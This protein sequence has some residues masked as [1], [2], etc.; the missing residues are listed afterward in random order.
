[1]AARNTIDKGVVAL[2]GGSFVEVKPPEITAPEVLYLA[3]RG[4]VSSEFRKSVETRPVNLVAYWPMD[5]GDGTVAQD[6]LGRFT[7]SLVGG[8]TWTTGR[9]GSG[10]SFNGTDGHVITQATGELLGIDGKKPRTIS[11]WA[12]ASN[13]NPMSQPGFYG[14]GDTNC[15]NG[16]NKYWG[17]RNIKDGG[18]TQL[19]S[20]HWCWD[21]RSNHGTD[22][23]V[24]WVHFA[25]I[26]NGSDVSV[27]INGDLISN[28]TRSQISTGNGQ[29]FQ[30][31]RWRNDTNAYYG[32]EMDDMRVYNDALSENEVQKIFQGEDLKEELVHLQFS[33][34][35]TQSPTSYGVSF[36]PNGLT[37]D[38]LTGEVTG[39]PLQI[40][41]FDVNLTATN[42]AGTGIKQIKLIIDPTAPTLTT[43]SPKDVSSSS[44]RLS[45]RVENDGGAPPALSFFWGD[46]DGGENQSVDLN[47]SGLWDYRIDLNGTYANG[48]VS[49]TINGLQKNGTYYYRLFGGNSVNSAVWSLPS[50]EGL[51]SWWSFDET[52]GSQALDSV[53]SRNA[54]LVGVSESDRI[55]GKVGR[56]LRLN[57][58]GEHVSVKG[59]KGIGAGKQRS[60]ALWLKVPP[61]TTGGSL[62]SWGGSG[63]GANWDFMIENG[64]LKLAVSGGQLTGA[65]I[66]NDD[67]W[68]HVGLVFPAIGTGVEDVVLYVDGSVESNPIK[69]P[70]MINTGDQWDFRVGTNEN[71]N[72]FMGLI[73]EVRLYEKDISSNEMASIF[74]NGTMRFQTSA[75]SLPPVV[76]VSSITPTGGGTATVSGV[77][78]AFDSTQP[79]LKIYW[80][81][82]DGGYD[83]ANWDNS[84]DVAGGVTQGLGEFNA[85][86]SGLLPG[87]T[88]YFRAF[89]SSADGLDWSNGDPEV[90]KSLVSHL[91][92]DESNGTLVYDSSPMTHTAFFQSSDPNASR[93]DG[94]SG[95]ALS[96]NGKDDWLNL[97]ANSSGFLSQSFDG[98]SVSF[99][100]RPTSKV[101]AGPAMTKYEDLVA[102]YP[103]DEGTGSVFGDL[104]VEN[105]DGDLFGAPAWTSAQFGQGLDLDGSNDIGELSAQG[106][107]RDLH[108]NS[109]TISLWVNAD[110]ENL[111]D[112]TQGQLYSHGFLEAI[113]D[114]YYTNIENMFKL[115][116][117]GSS[118]L[119]NGPG[120][121]GLDFNND[122][123][124]RNA[125]IGINRNNNYLSLFNGIF[126]AQVSGPYGWEIRGND[127]RGTIWIDLDQ[128]GV[129]EVAGNKGNEQLVYQPQCCGT[130]STIVMLEAGY[131]AIAIAHGEGGGGSN[132]EA[133]FYTPAGGGATTLTKIKPSD[134]PSLFM[135]SNERTLLKRGPMKLALDGNN[136][137]SYTHG[138]LTGQVTVDS[139]QSLGQ[140]NW[141][142]LALVA[143]YNSST[144]RFYFNGIKTDE[145]LLP[146]GDPV[147][148][149]ATEKWKLGGTNQVFSD[150]FDGK[151]DDMRFY[152]S[153]LN[154]S[155]ILAIF[156]DDLSGAAQAGYQQQ[157]LYDEGTSTSGL[158]ISLDSGVL[159]TKISE[160]SGT[161]ELVDVG[162]INDDKWHHVIVTFGDSPKTFKLYVDGLLKAG[163]SLLTE[164]TVSLHQ[165]V[166]SFGV[167]QGSSQYP[168]YGYFKGELDDFRIYDRG[169]ANSEV[170][171]IFSGDVPNDGFL[172]FLGIEKPDVE[173]KSAIEV[174]PSQAIMRAEIN[175]IG[176]TV[177]ITETTTDRSFK[178]DTIEG[179]AAWFSA[180][181]MNGDL[182]EDI[183]S[184]LG[185]GELV[186]TWNDA[187]GNGRHMSNTLGDPT[188]YLSSFEGKPVVNFDGG[189]LLSSTSSFDF[190]TNDGY[191][192]ISIARYTGGS[193]FRVI[194]SRTRNFLFGYHGGLTGRWYAEGWIST[195]GPFDTDWHLHVG[196]I[197]AKGGNPRAS[198]WRDGTSLTVGS[199]GSNNTNFAPGLLQFG[200]AGRGNGWDKS[201]CEIAEVM[202][203]DRELN[204]SERANIEGYLAHKWRSAEQLLASGHPHL[205]T[206]P[207][208]GVTKVT[209]VVTQGGDP[210]ILKIFW[211]DDWVE[212]NSTAVDENNASK[213]DHVIVLNQGN[214]V[215]LGTYETV[216]GNL[217]QNT[218]YYYRAYAEN[219][220][221]GSWAPSVKAFTA[222]DTR[223]TKHTM[224][225][226]LLWLDA[227]DPDGDGVRN[228]WLNEQ[229]VSLWVD[230]SKNEKNAVQSVPLA[231]PIYAPSVFDDM[232]AMRFAS[233]ESLNIGTLTL[234]STP[235]S[236]FVVAQGS[237]VVIGSNDGSIGWS[238]DAK[239]GIRLGSYRHE[240]NVLQQITLGYDPRTGYGQLIGE[241]GEVMVFDRYLEAD[242]RERI[243]GYLAHKW[244]ITEDLAG[245]TFKVK[246]GLSLYFPFEETD[247]GTVYDSSKAKR[248][249]TLNEIAGTDLSVA[250]KFGSGIKLGDHP[251]SRI[252]MGLNSVD[253]P[254]N[255]TISVWLETPL[256][257]RDSMG[258][259]LIDYWHTLASGAGGDVRHVLFDKEGN[260]E[261]G[262]YDPATVDW[263]TSGY[264]GNSMPAGWH[265]LGAVGLG[266]KTV[267]YVDGVEVGTSNFKINAAIDTIGNIPAGFER[268]TDKIDEFRVYGRPLSSPEI[269]T[270]YGNGLGDFGGHPYDTEAPTFDNV[271]VIKLP[272]NPIVHWSFDEL[273]GTSISD[274]SGLDHNGSVVGNSITNLYDH[275][276]QGRS[277]TALRFDEN[278]SV[279]LPKTSS[280][281]LDNTF[282]L[283]FW[284]NTNDVDAVILKSDQMKVEVSNGFISA[285]VYLGSWINTAEI[286]LT[287]GEWVHYT[288]MWDGS[289]VRFFVNASEVGIPISVS[290]ATLQGTGGDTNTYLG[291]HSSGGETLGGLFDDLRIFNQA[292]TMKELQGVFEFADSQLIARFGEEYE[293]QIESIKGP[294]EYNATGLPQGLEV[295]SATGLIYGEAN[296]TGI[297]SV[298]LRAANPS[299]EDYALVDLVVLKGRQS[300]IFEED[301]GIIVYGDSPIDLNVSSTS[302]L[303]ITFDILEGNESVDLNGSIMTI[304]KPGSV[305]VL[306]RQNGDSHWFAA[307]P[308]PLE[309]QIMKS[310]LVVTAIDQFRSTTESNPTLTYTVQGLVNGDSVNDFNQSIFISTVIGDGNFS[311]PT[312]AGV[313]PITVSNALSELYYFVF[314]NGSLT[315][316]D[317]SLQTLV[318][319]QNLTSV[320]ANLQSVDLQGY[321][322]DGNGTATG[323]PLLYTVEDESVAR[324]KVTRNEDLLAHWKLDEELYSSARDSEGGYHGTLV[325]LVNLGPS[326]SWT[327]GIFSNGL[328]LGSPSGR[329]ELGSVPFDGAFSLSFWLKAQ[330]VN[331]SASTILSK[332]GLLGMNLFKLQKDAGS[333]GVVFSFFGDGNSTAFDLNSSTPVLKQDEWVHLALT[334]DG[335][336][337]LSMYVDALQ[338][339]QTTGISISGMPLDQRYSNLKLGSSVNPFDGL[340]DDLRV[341]KSSLSLADLSQIFG[342]GGG[343]FNQLELVG[344][345]TTKIVASQ[346]GTDVYAQAVPV[347]NYLTVIKVPQS[348][349]FASI[350][351]HSVGDFPFLLEANATSGLS[352]SFSTSDPTRA[353]IN[354]NQV[355]IFGPGEV[356]ITAIQAGDSRFEPAQPVSRSFTIGFGNLFSDSAPGLKLWLDANDVNGDYNRDDQ[357][358]F[359]FGYKVSMWADKSGN[360]NN[361]IQAV[362]GNMTRWLPNTLNEKPVVSFDAGQSF[363]IQN[364]VPSPQFVF[365]VH[366]QSST[367]ASYVLGGDL[368]TTG[369]DGFFE[370]SH[371]SENVRIVSE[372]PSNYW[373]VNSLRVVP[374]GQSLWINGEIVGADSYS[375][376]AIAF[377]QL[378]Q[379][380]MGEIA[381]VL[382]FD[383]AVNSVNRK[384]IEGYLAHKWGLKDQLG[385]LHPYHTDPPAFGG[386]Q[387]ISFPV[388]V[389]KAVGDATFP[390]LA[391]SSS[392]LPVSYVSSNPSVAVVVGN[393]VTVLGA[394]STTITAMQMGDD[395]YH[396]A[397]PVS[398]VLHVVPP[399][400][401]DDQY[402]TFQPIPEKVRDDPAFELNA[403]A[404]SSGVNHPVYSLPVTFTVVSGPASVNAAGVLVLD[405]MEGNVS[406]TATQ[407]GSAYVKAAAP[408]TQIFEVSSRQRQEIRFPAPGTGGL[409]LTPRGHRPL[410]LQGVS[411]TSGLPVQ[412]T[413]SDPS[414]AQVFRG[415]RVIPRKS[416]TVTLTFNSPGN[417]F[418]VPAEPQTKSF[419]V[420]EPS[421]SV[422][423]AF[424]RGDVRY[425]N[426]TSRFS[427]RLLSRNPGL[428]QVEALKIFDEDYTDSDGDGY[429]NLFERALGTDSLGP[430][431]RHDLPMQPLHGDNRQ[432]ISFIRWKADP[433][434][435]ST[436]SN[437]GEVF[438]YHVEQSDDLE[439]WETAGVVLEQVVDLG[440]GM[441]RATYVTS[442]PLPS[443]QRK[444]VR[445]RIT[446]P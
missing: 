151:V 62:V 22:I 153:D 388:L 69:N 5:E 85:T 420:V 187:S 277:G 28:W 87:E 91:R 30:F 167:T 312:P 351:D 116:P 443:G 315:V 257:E 268:F 11:F 88:Y 111:G 322:L 250:G 365:I 415:S 31:G 98:R 311:S 49:T 371:A 56:A 177:T 264:G 421:R 328:D 395:R 318:F 57:G 403:T 301:L 23:R 113:Q 359:I 81:N 77:L 127:D 387:T 92:F 145:E 338:I 341:Y 64:R 140:G 73:D 202:I 254:N 296:Q 434:T 353:V 392:G 408:V 19:I 279:Y 120:G 109:Y 283:C 212:N 247:G 39:K 307:E 419:T 89:A 316:S 327:R 7:G 122:G 210:P 305:R 346:S 14:Y 38:P 386:P 262:V 68:H 372:T 4:S 435:N 440:G 222:S 439:T 203:F 261:L 255:W 52:T 297:F 154:D 168:G 159:R 93:P 97:D 313:Y 103:M 55:F 95:R 321:S 410:V 323:L 413:S 217:V 186:N 58:S 302:G 105:L 29:T 8:A 18:Y 3:Y 209:D 135:T 176:G 158:S 182:T 13:N 150:Y 221:G 228:D 248:N 345:G 230:K 72:H 163:P 337:T 245:T 343:D 191:T 260:K 310:E 329:V 282:T 340:V 299:G 130:Q 21:P 252:T 418:F 441:E 35:A 171:S 339:A 107:L 384:K 407:S 173:T 190:L 411:V 366:R 240:S 112:Y 382:V 205:S 304:K 398:R 426:I 423:K 96:F 170:N 61:S 66:L 193:S 183:G 162:S 132:Q 442:D 444:F 161:V 114:D 179:M 239:S 235:M 136:T 99:R 169:L 269:L 332:D 175:S 317:K 236:V 204:P 78:V 306:A 406:I 342:Q 314:L 381:E 195:A 128:D 42:L 20:Q 94:F 104:G 143:D 402:I 27:S 146:A 409:R 34:D 185:N 393:Y 380:F 231:Q 331:G 272:N 197:E 367:G 397:S 358:D 207:Y 115:T 368:A 46:N 396:P 246:E 178:P 274:S 166:P 156:Q 142:H 405:G 266:S 292:L 249:A 225:G 286:P 391:L 394:G 298:N 237:G 234:G 216:V 361:P 308:L 121:R 360:T 363:D 75:V 196:T 336:A 432:R 349:S 259:L 427:S 344:S 425:Q 106:K 241:I 181:D 309:F 101:Y 117:S 32:G 12:K 50:Q 192:M 251:R 200:G 319:D 389:D 416:G 348:M 129:F 275:S 79:A 238:L 180:Q 67:A 265:H 82:E 48:L 324:L 226:L 376:G 369:P 74:L 51:S 110:S 86:V 417:A 201:S 100:L 37:I 10:L 137:I 400:V 253:L 218:R 33:I 300:I 356:T 373:A 334:F 16:L 370:L 325:N 271:P 220:G 375:Q 141:A 401:K 445:L 24:D 215:T 133:Y 430:D 288:L 124:Y 276:E 147:D 80:G 385:L 280:S 198:F 446:I 160:G 437:V 267:F 118:T 219:L 213:W 43:D 172:E 139:N 126:H 152:A 295:D 428:T 374:N 326:N 289:K 362:D 134:Y 119:T 41:V 335:N 71:G 40:G 438:E 174:M 333:G 378:G 357:Y 223:F 285:G 294:T 390:L 83:V 47:N 9:F 433:A 293:Y 256:V 422:W 243:E 291:A 354:G 281:S 90:R 429:S 414:I 189:D 242:D 102:Y 199:T 320:R 379:T 227:T 149:L 26:Y 157:I 63:N 70:R 144:L 284:L 188:Y 330:D 138:N 352:V 214:P 244:G 350:V 44:A 2:G 287:T 270:L 424:R 194:S 347:P 108:K 399:G 412:I 60:L 290:N 6:A 431:R 15:P 208:G 211:G 303:P 131:Y 164:S 25:H 1:M 233:G 45:G 65:T 273:N 184:V 54:T 155:E 206:N 383:Q 355:Q 59:F 232:P 84:V 165:E 148:L 76:E 53:G 224:D 36:I 263:V 258:D 436:Y 229:K 377:D 278:Q 364:S 123:D 125:G 404:I 17:I